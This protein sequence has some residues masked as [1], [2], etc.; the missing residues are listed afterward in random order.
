[1]TR[2]SSFVANNPKP[3]TK[4]DSLYTRIYAEVRRI[5]RARVSTYGCIARLVGGCSARQ[6]GYAMAALPEGSRV[7]W[8]RVINYKGEISRRKHGSGSD[9]QRQKLLAEVIYF[10]SKGRIDLQRY[11]WPRH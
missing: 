10:D 8:H 4:A 9:N 1:M 3:D 11:G 7:P 2:I 6:V 5:P